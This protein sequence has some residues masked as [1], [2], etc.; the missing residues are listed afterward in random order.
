[1]CR[2]KKKS[3][4]FTNKGKGLVSEFKAF[5]TKGNVI[6]MAVGVIVGGAFSAIITAIINCILMP[7]ITAAIPNGGIDGLVTVL[8]PGISKVADADLISVGENVVYYWG[9]AYD[10]TKVAIIN[11]GGVVNALIYFFA[12]ALILFVILKVFTGLKN[13]RLQIQAK[14]KEE[15]YKKHPEERPV[16]EPEPEPEPTEIDI[17]KEILEE[18]KKS[19]EVK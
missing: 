5:I 4:D 3:K 1:M 15:Y 7:L 17:L 11:W 2:K 8:N 13:K 18:V 14:M 10:S 19:K 16:V 9:Q 6:D 12:V